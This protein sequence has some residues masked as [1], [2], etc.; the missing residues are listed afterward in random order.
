MEMSTNI[1]HIVTDGDS[2]S[3]SSL[4]DEIKVDDIIFLGPMTVLLLDS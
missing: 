1:I 4:G 3:Q 2:N